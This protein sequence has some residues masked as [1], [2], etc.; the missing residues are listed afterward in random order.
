MTLII[1]IITLLLN[2]LVGLVVCASIDT[3]DGRLLAWAEQCPIPGGTVWVASMWPVMLYF[4]Y[5][6]KKK[7][8]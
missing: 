1:I 3:N 7:C 4:W 8:L 5:K 6:E 2:Y